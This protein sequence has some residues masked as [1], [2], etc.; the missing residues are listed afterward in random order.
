MSGADWLT[1]DLLDIQICMPTN[2]YVDLFYSCS[3]NKLFGFLKGAFANTISIGG[4][5]L[6]FN[7]QNEFYIIRVEVN[8]DDEAND[9]FIQSIFP[10]TPAKEEKTEEDEL[11]EILSED[12]A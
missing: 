6:A 1:N 7:R 2:D 3:K 9:K 8:C 12:S 4:N 11:D 5:I 10:P